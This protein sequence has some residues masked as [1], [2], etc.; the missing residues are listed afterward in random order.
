MKALRRNERNYECVGYVQYPYN[1]EIGEL[2]EDHQ[3]PA[4][5]SFV[6]GHPAVLRIAATEEEL[7]DKDLCLTYRLYEPEDE[8]RLVNSDIIE[9][10]FK[11]PSMID[12]NRWRW[13]KE[14]GKV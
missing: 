5:I 9:I 11:I 1:D 7:E 14:K 6:D 2:P 4:F 12:L 10:H 13:D 3:L 8:Q